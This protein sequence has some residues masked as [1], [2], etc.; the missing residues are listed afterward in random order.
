MSITLDYPVV[1]RSRFGHGR[2][3][4]RRLRERLREGDDR[5][6]THL[7]G[8]A[9]VADHLAKLPVHCDGLAEHEPRWCNG[10]IP[11]L[12]AAA[13]YA[14]GCTWRWGPAT[15]RRSRRAIGDHG[16]DTTIVSI[17][18]H[19][20]SAIDAIC[21]EVVRSPV[22]EVD[23][24]VFERLQPGDVLFVDNSHRVLPNSD[25]MVMFME[26]LPRLPAGVHVQFHDV[27]LPDDYLD[28]WNDRYYSDTPSSTSWR[29][30]CWVA[31]ACSAPSCPAGTSRTTRP[32]SPPSWR[33]C[34]SGCQ[35]P[36]GMGTRSGS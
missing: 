4:H 7:E 16:L 29:H 18:P 8:I 27:F 35:G 10:W 14:L 11:G 12:D 13:L 15:P 21:D 31:T 26:V 9:A 34:S 3:T 2:P 19:P 25:A 5:Y 36:S 30:S 32:T 24:S 1:P 33:R 20:R 17:D 6:R 22:E 23:L 28:E